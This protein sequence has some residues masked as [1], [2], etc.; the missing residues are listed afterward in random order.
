MSLVE[1]W[2]STVMRSNERLTH[3]AEQQVARL[4][5]TAARRSARS[6]ASSRS[7]AGSSRRPWPA[8]SAG[9]SRR[10]GRRRARRACRARRWC[11]SRARA[12]RR[13][14]RAARAAAAMQA[15][16]DRDL[17][18]ELDA[19]D[20][21]RADRDLVLGHAR[22]HRRAALHPRGL[23]EP[24][25]AGRGVRVARVGDDGAQRV[26]PAALAGDRSPAAPAT[27]RARE[28][29]GARRVGRVG[30]DDPEVEAPSGL[31]P[32]ATPPA[33]KPC[34]SRA[35]SAASRTCVGLLDP[36]ARR[37]TPSSRAPPSRRG[38]T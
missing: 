19:D 30:H 31:M 7:S 27:P 15:R 16:D 34:G 11:G 3:H 37:R 21:G 20:A 5:A 29:R 23:V 1:S 4:G 18:V 22:D 14:P 12:P 35:S 10:G 2:P 36:A 6:R 9:P 33:R 26:E 25:A 17:P 8:R 38:R 32:A 28:P 13:R 24:A